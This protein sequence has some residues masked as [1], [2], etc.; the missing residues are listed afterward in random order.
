MALLTLTSDIGLQDYLVGAVKGRLWQADPAFI[1]T[2][3]THQLPPFNYP[4]AAYICWNAIKNFPDYTFHIILVNLFE[5]KPDRLLLAFHHN[6]YILCADN[7]L[8][9]MIIEGR[10]ELVIAL[11]VDKLQTKNT[12]YRVENRG[13]GQVLISG[14]KKFCPDPVLVDFQGS[15][16]GTP[17]CKVRYIGRGMFMEFHHPVLGTVTTTRVRDIRELPMPGR[18]WTSG[19]VSQMVS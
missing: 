6:Q 9:T 19:N 10:P 11:P 8:L 5:R 15:T 16:W 7:G 3:I 14:N 18:S 13:D 12:L 1:I 17:M 4:Q 2:D